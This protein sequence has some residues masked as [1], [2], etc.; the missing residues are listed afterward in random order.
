LIII[1]LLALGGGAFSAAAA[2]SAWTDLFQPRFGAW[3]QEPAFGNPDSNPY[4]AA[5]QHM[6]P[7]ILKGGEEAS[8]FIAS[9]DDGGARLDPACTY[10]LEGRSPLARLFTL[11]AEDGAGRPILAATP[12]PSKLHSDLLLFEGSTYRISVSAR[13][14]PGNWLAIPAGSEFLLVLTTYDAA[15]ADGLA[16]SGFAPPAIIK[17][18]CT[19]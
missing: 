18:E 5:L 4:V 12:L 7:R 17:G 19:P 11:R 2:L 1:L 16:A 10:L 3:H 8:V 13:A 15:L 9:T 6:S 14:Q